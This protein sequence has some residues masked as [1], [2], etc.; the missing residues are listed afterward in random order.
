MKMIEWLKTA[1]QQKKALPILSFPG[2]QITGKTVHELVTSSD[3]QVDCMCAIAD[4]YDTLAS[5]SLM[6]LSVEAEAFGSHV[7]FS[8]DE[9][10]STVGSLVATEADA[11]ALP[12]PK[13]GDARTGL[14]IDAVEKAL[15]RITDRPIF[16][17]VL[18]PFSLAGRLIGVQEILIKAYREPALIHKTLEK[19]TR[20]SIEY[21]NA[22][23]AVGAHGVMMAEPVAG[24]LPPRFLGDFSSSYVKRI[25]EATEDENF[26]VL[27]HNCGPVLGSIQKILSAGPRAMHFGNTIDLAEM[28]KSIPADRI[29][30]GN[31]DPA[32]IL[33]D[34]T[35]ASVREAT[36][37]VLE[38]CSGYQ[39]FI[40]SS[41]C[42][43]PPSAPLKNLD[44]F[45]D[46]A[47]EFYG[48]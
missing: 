28:G 17:G 48:R 44:S 32:G 14:Y 46:T 43:I 9:I 6:D 13:V 35:P 10:P 38:A 47:K 26:L 3:A 22:Y 11:D 2:H 36:L 12:L 15:K 39:N 24:L 29:F 16:A 30:M 18:G 8:A 7:R 4:R 23:K 25:I 34:G 21:I 27:Y 37:R 41:G 20:F 31:V 45:F 5:V 42:D 1:P 40:L 19:A 33:H